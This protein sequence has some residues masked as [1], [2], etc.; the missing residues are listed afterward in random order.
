MWHQ[1]MAHSYQVV[2]SPSNARCVV[3][4]SSCARCVDT[5]GTRLEMLIRFVDMNFHTLSI[6][7]S[8]YIH[9]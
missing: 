1:F 3:S 2:N 7:D 6:Q 5:S 4:Q 8:F 9:C